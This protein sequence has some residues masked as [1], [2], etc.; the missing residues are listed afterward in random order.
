MENREIFEILDTQSKVLVGILLKRIELLEKENV[1]T[2]N[3]YKALT[4]EHI[5]EWIRTVKAL[6]NGSVQFKTKDSQS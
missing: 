6:I 3:L 2:S 1:L 5:Y 4:K